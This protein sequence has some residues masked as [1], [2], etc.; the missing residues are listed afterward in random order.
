MVDFVFAVLA[1][2]CDIVSTILTRFSF[3]SP[4]LSDVLECLCFF[5]LMLLLRD[6]DMGWR[7][8]DVD[9]DVVVERLCFLILLCAVFC[10]GESGPGE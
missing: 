6:D 9:V 4:P 8:V 3:G 10:G 1:V 2:C 5:F 7:Y